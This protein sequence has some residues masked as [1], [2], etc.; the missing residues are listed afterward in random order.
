MFIDAS[1]IVAILVAEPEMGDL[2][3]RLSRGRRCYTSPIAIYE[4]VL[5]IA[6]IVEEPTNEVAPLVDRLLAHFNI[7]V[8]PIDAGIGAAA[9]DAFAQF[10]RGRHAAALNFGDCFSYACAQQVGGKL[11]YKGDDFAKTDIRS[12]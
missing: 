12:A 4:A 5:G 3:R 8:M 9:L 1:A 11:L 7:E 10:G 6:R 2:L